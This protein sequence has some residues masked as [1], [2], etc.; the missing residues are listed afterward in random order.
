[1]GIFDNLTKE[2]NNDV[3]KS[4]AEL[5]KPIVGLFGHYTEEYFNDNLK[6]K[7]TTTKSQISFCDAHNEALKLCYE[8]FIYVSDHP[9]SG[10]AY[11][12]QAL[13]DDYD[14]SK[15]NVKTSSSND[16]Y[17]VYPVSQNK[18][19]SLTTDFINYYNINAIDFE[20]Q[21]LTNK[22]AD[23]KEKIHKNQTL[24][25]AYT[26]CEGQKNRDEKCIQEYFKKKYKPVNEMEETKRN[27]IMANRQLNELNTKKAYVAENQDNLC[28]QCNTNTSYSNFLKSSLTQSS[29]AV[30]AIND[31]INNISN[32]LK[33]NTKIFGMKRNV[34]GVMTTIVIIMIILT[35]GFVA[36]FGYKAAQKHFPF[37]VNG[38][39]AS[40][41]S[42]SQPPLTSQ[43]KTNSVNSNVSPFAATTTK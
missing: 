17:N 40:Q 25:D 15:L 10:Q 11:Y 2:L 26:N 39:R 1:M 3:N 35:I 14:Y 21:N 5:F 23:L 12:G 28:K 18:C 29:N 20:K 32:K 38:F 19:S 9:S 37:T 4:E 42:A 13:D 7:I 30:A 31:T 36:Y 24:I 43:I 33:T 41:A 34:I 22:V 16:A 6:N 27:T 8:Y